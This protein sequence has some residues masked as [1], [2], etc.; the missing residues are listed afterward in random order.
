MNNPNMQMGGNYMNNPNMQMG[1]N[2]MNNPNMQMGGNYMNYPQGQY[3]QGQQYGYG[4]DRFRELDPDVRLEAPPGWYDKEHLRL[5]A[6]KEREKYFYN[7]EKDITE[8][9]DKYISY[10]QK[11]NK[12]PY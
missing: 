8:Y 6:S 10:V 12:N 4:R 1:G 11:Q 7:G 9:Q 3:N 5:Q 2:Y